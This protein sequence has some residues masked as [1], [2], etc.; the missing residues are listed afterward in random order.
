MSEIERIKM[1]NPIIVIAGPTA[2]GKS[3]LAI[4]LA[5]A[6][7][8]V[9][10]NA[11]SMQIYQ[12]TPILSATPNIK[13]KQKVEHRLYELFPNN[14]RSSVVDWLNKIVPEIRSLWGAN[15]IPIVVGGTGLYIDNLINGTTP[16][17]ETSKEAHKETMRLLSEYGVQNLY[18]KLQEVDSLTASR[19]SEN[20]TT[21]IRRAYEVWLDTKIPLSVW[22]KKEMLK[23]LPEAHFFVIKIIPD[24]TELD[25]RC[26]LRFD[27]MIEQGA[28][29]EVEKLA[30]QNLDETLPAMKALGVPEILSYLKGETSLDEAVAL[31]KLHTR[32][33]AKRQLTWFRHKLKADFEI[34][35]CYQTDDNLIKNIIFNVKN[36]L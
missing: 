34:K 25:E 6:M 10:L 12:G 8:G 36:E 24:K 19:L 23:K 28:L 1:E 15:K 14:F 9:I 27:K 31:A 22:H 33:Y 20:D 7:N 21:R 13:D 2:S 16:V 30:K 17:P 5:L 11:D 3:Q 18:K 29:S 35:K 26:Y 32:Q 4:D